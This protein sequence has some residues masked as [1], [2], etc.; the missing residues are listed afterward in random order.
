MR[1][2]G[3]SDSSVVFP[4]IAHPRTHR[5]RSSRKYT[6]LRAGSTARLQPQYATSTA[7]AKYISDWRPTS[8]RN[9]VSAGKYW[10]PLLKHYHHAEFPPPICS[11]VLD[12]AWAGPGLTAPSRL[13]CRD[14]QLDGP[15]A[16]WSILFLRAAAKSCEL[17]ALWKSAGLIL[18][19]VTNIVEDVS[20]RSPKRRSQQQLLTSFV[21]TV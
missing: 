3:C 19:E 2:R 16:W 17:L 13:Y 1:P 14:H 11:P 4:R 8:R 6:S 15:Q 20:A 9:R 12:L 18:L 10:M 5:H 21:A 7:K